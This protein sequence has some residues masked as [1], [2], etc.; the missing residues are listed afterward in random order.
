MSNVGGPHINGRLSQSQIIGLQGEQWA[1][2]QLRKRGHPVK[3][4]ADFTTQNCDLKI[5][6]LPIEVKLAWPTMRRHHGKLKW[7]W[8]FR[9]H[10]TSQQME[11]DWLLIL[12]ARDYNGFTYPYILPGG[13]LL[14]R[15]H[16]QITSHPAKF[17]GWLSYW[18]NRW[19]VVD[20]L[21]KKAYR[22]GGLMYH[23][24]E[25]LRVG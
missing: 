24:W 10:P 6:D 14:E 12:I 1:Y 8:Q 9:I 20:Y 17:R 4:V 11:C 23:H 21:L 3:M 19:S 22:D 7:R 25:R 15:Q 18:L 2:E 13:L 5:R 16:I